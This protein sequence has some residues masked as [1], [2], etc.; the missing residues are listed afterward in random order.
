M[1]KFVPSSWDAG[2]EKLQI[3]SGQ[4]SEVGS[5]FKCDVHDSG[6][7]TDRMAAVSAK[8]VQSNA[9]QCLALHAVKLSKESEKM[10]QTAS[11][12][13]LAEDAC[14]KIARLLNSLLGG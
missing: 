4:L 6:S 11:S 9:S 1:V 10:G 7:A 3:I 5:N 14:E 12:Y 8:V 2:A 13:R